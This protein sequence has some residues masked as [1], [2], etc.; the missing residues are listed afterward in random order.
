MTQI[1]EQQQIDRGNA[2]EDLINNQTFKE[3]FSVVQNGAIQ[4]WMSSKPEEAEQRNTA[5]YL[6]RGMMDFA[7]VLNQQIQIRDQILENQN[8]DSEA[9]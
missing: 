4:H 7:A 5:Y 9:E 2:A 1:S 8:Q 3:T 6:V